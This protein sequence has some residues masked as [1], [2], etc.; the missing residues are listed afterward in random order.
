MYQDKMI[1]CKECGKEFVFSASEQE[2][3]EAKGF[4]HEP[5]RC[6]ACRRARKQRGEQAGYTV[7]CADCGKETKVPFQ[8]K[9][10]RPVY[11]EECYA[12]RKGAGSSGAL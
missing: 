1:V 5:S 11:C 7:V 12:R 4:E 2:F 6:P 10:G 8:P 9:E 3:Y